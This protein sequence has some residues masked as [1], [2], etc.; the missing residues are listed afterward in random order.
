MTQI[1]QVILFAI[2]LLILALIVIAMFRDNCRTDKEVARCYAYIQSLNK[3]KC[4]KGIGIL[5]N[6]T[7]IALYKNS[8]VT[9][10]LKVFNVLYIIKSNGDTTKI[11]DEIIKCIK[12]LE[13]FEDYQIQI[14]NMN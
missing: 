10:D 3:L 12:I 13:K 14:D 9:K 7:L 1:Q 2:M 11:I 6:N 5:T 8:E 4:N